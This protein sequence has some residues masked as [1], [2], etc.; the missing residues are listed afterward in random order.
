MSKLPVGGVEN[1]LLTV[2]S[3]YDKTRFSPVVCSLADK[4][5]IGKEIEEL[6][7]EVFCLNKLNHRF[8]YS[9]VKDIYGLIRQRDIA[10]V[11]THQYHA[12][13]YGRLAARRAGVPCIIASVHNVYTRD[14]KIHRRIINRY[15]ARFTDR[16]VA[17]SEAVKKDITKYDGLT[18]DKIEV[19]CNGVD[20]ERFSNLDRDSVRTKLDI[21]REVPVI[22]TVGRLTFQKGQKYLLEAVSKL[23]NKFP[24]LVLLIVGDGP[25][26][27][28]LEHY[29]ETLGIGR[30]TKFLDVRRD[31]PE[32]LSVMDIFVLPSLWEGLVN[33]L[34]EAMAAGKPVI[35][36]DIP[37]IREII[38]SEDV[39]LLVP[40]KNSDAIAQSV[41][42]LLNN[43]ETANDLSTAAYERASSAF[44]IDATV[45][46]YTEL[47]E[48]ILRKKQYGT[49]GQHTN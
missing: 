48:N 7:I 32:L 31:I 9:I 29:S 40:P 15:L 24:G 21:E 11:R 41:E 18:D 25:A 8:D 26:R 35:A 12:N 33:A 17:V 14:K 5:E 20:I 4:G 46:K 43:K 47:F 28:E 22:G 36:S 13:L 19:I 37:Q 34:I 30:N 23:T 42:L 2:L 45:N 44:S 39:G 27:D 1:Q 3:K 49:S 38:N 10:V 16:V 6:G